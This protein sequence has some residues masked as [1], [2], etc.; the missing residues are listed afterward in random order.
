V[1]SDRSA[2][3]CVFFLA[4]F[5]TFRMSSQASSRKGTSEPAEVSKTKV[6]K[7][8]TTDRPS[9]RSTTNQTGAATAVTALLEKDDVHNANDGRRYLEKYLLLCPAG[10][11][12]TTNSLGYCLHQI[13]EMKGIKNDVANAVRAAAYLIEEIEEHSVNVVVRDAVISQLNELTQ[14]MKSLVEDAKEKFDTY[15]QSKLSETATPPS[16][17]L[18][19]NRDVP[20]VLKR[21]TYGDALI[22]PPPHADPRLAAREGIRARQILLEG[23][24][25]TSKVGQMNGTQLKV[26]F[27][28]IFEQLG[29]EE[30]GVRSVT[31]QK[32]KGLL[33]EMESD[34]ASAWVSKA[35][36]RFALCVEIG[37]DVVVRPRAH[38]V[39]AFNIPLTFDPEKQEHLAE[40]YEANHLDSE[41]IATTRW[42]K[43]IARRIPEQKSAHLSISF[44]DASAANRA[45]ADGI[46]ICNKRV[47]VEKVKKEPTRCLKCQGWN[48]HAYECISRDDKC[49]NCAENHRTSQCPHPRRTRCISCNVD[50]HASWSRKC[51]TYL[52]KVDNCN[53]RNPENSLQF[54]PTTEPW[55]WTPRTEPKFNKPPQY[56][57]YRPSWG[58]LGPLPDWNT[59]IPPS[60]SWDDDTPYDSAPLVKQTITTTPQPRADPA[61]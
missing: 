61:T 4:D 19:D 28:R 8:T 37:P 36:N 14:D 35:E 48:H 41:T 7:A 23:I 30:K 33:V 18:P 5:S 22:S 47:R 11:P 56:D 10:E 27:N 2:I 16:P 57:S 12:L 40:F 52:K 55:T 3:H 24:D 13:S 38:T 29:F 25:S 45:I 46:S 9:T 21:K 17:P 26:E 15:V 51:P 34:R 32:K 60:R 42:V 31:V 58:A 59:D 1:A 39:I 43:P 53:L 20:G 44:T 50:D 6:R 49:G 54:F